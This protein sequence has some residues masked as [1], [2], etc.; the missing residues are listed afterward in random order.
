MPD[1]DARARL[2]TARARSSSSG[3]A[4]T[5]TRECCSASASASADATS[6]HHLLPSPRSLA[7]AS[8]AASLLVYLCAVLWVPS[9]VRL[10]LHGEGIGETRAKG[11]KKKIAVFFAFRALNLFLSSSKKK[12]ST[13]LRPWT[14][15]NRRPPRASPSAP[16]GSTPR[17]ASSSHG[18]RGIGCSFP[19]IFPPPPLYEV[20]NLRFLLDFGCTFI[21]CSFWPTSF[22]VRQE[23]I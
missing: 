23:S 11:R 13:L 18:G 9:Q 17:A 15:N 7:L 19:G 3:A 12:N 2:M 6:L 20:G 1:A 16:Q 4:G 5:T 21:P 14:P 8:L 22:K 10:W